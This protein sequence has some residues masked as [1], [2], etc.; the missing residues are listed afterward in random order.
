MPVCRL[1]KRSSPV[2]RIKK[3]EKAK[4]LPTATE[5]SDGR[6]ALGKFIAKKAKQA[7]TR[8]GRKGKQIKRRTVHAVNGQE[9]RK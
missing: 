1:C 3:S 6:D 2:T 4:G 7:A 8:K 9:V 5:L